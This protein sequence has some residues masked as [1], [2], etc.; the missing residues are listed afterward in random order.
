[1]KKIINLFVLL[2]SILLQFPT[3]NMNVYAVENDSE[4]IEKNI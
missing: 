4:I 1:M 2:I 3:G